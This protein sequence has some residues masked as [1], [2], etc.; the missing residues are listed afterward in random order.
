[1]WGIL[2]YFIK[3]SQS[4]LD[5][6]LI[7]D[8]FMNSSGRGPDD[9]YFNYQ[10]NKYFLGF[11]RLSIND[12]S[13]NGNQPFK[14][15]CENGTTYTVFYNGEIYNSVELKKLFPNYEFKSSSDCEVIIPLFIAHS[16]NVVNML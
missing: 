4:N 13:S 14:F 16:Y 6:P 8:N 3:N 1:M 10:K 5:Y 9:C 15:V 7:F 12:T 11:H 2:V